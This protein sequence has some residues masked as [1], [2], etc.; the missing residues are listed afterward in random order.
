MPKNIEKDLDR[1]WD[2]VW[3]NVLIMKMLNLFVI[4]VNYVQI[5]DFY[6]DKRIWEIGNIYMKRK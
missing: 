6:K 1:C 3:K 5:S 2:S 4:D